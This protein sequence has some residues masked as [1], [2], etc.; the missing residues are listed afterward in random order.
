MKDFEPFKL[1]LARAEAQIDELRALLTQRGPIGEDGPS[2]LLAFFQAR[3]DLLGLLARLDLGISR[4]DAYAHELN[5][6]A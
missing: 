1:D 5:H 4:P 6:R 2:G 3:R